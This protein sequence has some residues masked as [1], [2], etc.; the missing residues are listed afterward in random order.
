MHNKSPHQSVWQKMSGTQ[1]FTFFG[2]MSSIYASNIR[3][4]RAHLNFDLHSKNDVIN[5]KLAMIGFHQIDNALAA[6]ACANE[7]GVSLP[8]IK[9]GLEKTTIEKVDFNYLRVIPSRY[10]MTVIMPTLTL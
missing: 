1:K 3:H 8:L 7:L 2:N 6:A 9:E 5:I 4:E 10:W